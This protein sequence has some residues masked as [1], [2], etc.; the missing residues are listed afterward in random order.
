MI[1]VLGFLIFRRI[2]TGGETLAKPIAKA[3]VAFFLIVAPLF[4][5]DQVLLNFTSL[6]LFL[7]FSSIYDFMYFMWNAAGLIVLLS[8]VRGHARGKFSLLP[9]ADSLAG[10]G[11]TGPA[12]EPPGGSGG[13]RY[14][15]SSLS[16]MEVKKILSRIRFVMEDSKAY[17][18][19]DFDLQRLSRLTGIPRGRISQAL[20]QFAQ[21]T[22][23]DFLNKSRLEDAKHFLSDPDRPLSILETAFAAGFKS[24]TTFYSIFK[25]AEGVSPSEFRKKHLGSAAESHTV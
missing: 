6:D 14:A 20:N 4:T 5:L 11:A 25:K 17:R 15:K 21:T 10:G 9:S 8:M 3:M 12:A 2:R 19:P 16:R 1:S 22:F 23:Y 18:D 24:K 13:P 7:P